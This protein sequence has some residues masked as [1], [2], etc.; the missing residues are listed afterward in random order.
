[1]T[2]STG[3]TGQSNTLTTSAHP[4]VVMAVALTIA[5]LALGVYV[6]GTGPRRMDQWASETL[7][8]HA[9]DGLTRVMR[10]VTDLGSNGFAIPLMLL[11]VGWLIWRQRRQTAVIVA[12]FW[13]AAKLTGSV[14]KAVFDRDRPSLFPH[15]HDAG[16]YSYPSGHTVTAVITYGLIAALLVH[17]RHGYRRWAL[18]AVAAL[19]VIAVATSRIYLGVHYLTDVVG[20]IVITGA[21]LRIAILVLNRRTPCAG[22]V[23]AEQ[24]RDGSGMKTG[25][26]G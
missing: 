14:A 9:T 3:K 13:I 15:L 5:F 12:G 10:L 23:G 19:L 20:S 16:G 11:V 24:Q 8:R 26:S 6:S 4:G 21:W 17:C 7:H 22:N 18:I 1:V 2:G 25:V